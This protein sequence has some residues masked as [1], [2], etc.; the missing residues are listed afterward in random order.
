MASGKVAFTFYGPSFQSEILSKNP[1]ANIGMMPIPSLTAGG[2]AT[3]VGGEKT[4]WGVWKDT[5]SKE[6][7]LKFV[8]YYAKTENIQKVCK[9]S[10]LPAG[11]S[12]VKVDDGTLTDYFTKYNDVT[13]CPY[14]DRAYLPD[15]MWD[16]MTT[17]AGN[18][19]SGSITPS[20]Y[21]ANMKTEFTRLKSQTSSASN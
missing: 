18:M 11:L 13:V 7:A 9:S 2:K 5:K 3:F 4:T 8:D 16:V 10:G 6:A 19:I 12:N 15:G 14:F 17:N 21:S 1:N 20:Q